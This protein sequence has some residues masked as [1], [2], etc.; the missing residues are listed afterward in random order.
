LR[1][2]FMSGKLSSSTYSIK[3]KILLEKEFLKLE[4]ECLLI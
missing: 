3:N 4:I 1:F 2:F